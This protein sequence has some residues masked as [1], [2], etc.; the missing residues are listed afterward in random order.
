MKVVVDLRE[1]RQ[2]WK[3]DTNTHHNVAVLSIVP[4]LDVEVDCTPEQ[5][6]ALVQTTAQQNML[7]PAEPE[8]DPELAPEPTEDE[9]FGGDFEAEQQVVAAPSMFQ[10]EPVD[11]EAALAAAQPPQPVR[12]IP[13][14]AQQQREEAIETQRLRDPGGQ[15]AA[16]KQSMRQR[17]QA[18]PPRRVAKDDM[19]NPVV[20]PPTKPI[21]G[22]AGAPTVV[23]RA[24][25]TPIQ[26]ADDDGFSQG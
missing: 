12:N 26:G 23:R 15:R 9:V 22:S 13:K 14:S 25:T 17:A 11:V 19:G 10:A 2:I 3:A 1:I 16:N 8:P 24:P 5:V 21:T 4:G 6:H 20:T 7:T 18:V